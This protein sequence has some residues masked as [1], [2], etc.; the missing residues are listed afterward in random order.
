[1]VRSN[2]N[3]LRLGPNLGVK[4]LGRDGSL[5]QTITT[6]LVQVIQGQG[7]VKFHFEPI[8]T[9]LNENKP[10]CEGSM[11]QTLRTRLVK[12]NQGQGQ[13]KLHLAPIGLKLGEN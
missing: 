2:F 10:G 13:V 11:K 1:M 12:V 6:R 4:K 9:K 8:F 7:Q 3:L 5:K